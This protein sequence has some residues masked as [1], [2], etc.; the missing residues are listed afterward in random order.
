MKKILATA[1]SAVALTAA[2]TVVAPSATADRDEFCPGQQVSVGMQTTCPFG[3]NVRSAYYASGQM[4]NIAA[5]SPTLGTSIAMT[6]HAIT[7]TLVQCI[8]GDNA[9]VYIWK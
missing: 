5:Y 7:G 4:S 1:A 6:C 9:L 2:A 8:G 3:E